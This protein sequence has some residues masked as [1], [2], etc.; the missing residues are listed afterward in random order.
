[1]LEPTPA[2]HTSPG[3]TGLPGSWWAKLGSPQVRH[4]FSFGNMAEALGT[5][6]DQRDPDPGDHSCA[7]GSDPGRE[8]AT[9]TPV[10]CS[11]QSVARW[12]RGG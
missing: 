7:V 11:A 1:M 2:G 10:I 3:D 5:W 8:T 6:R 12:P 4:P 9:A